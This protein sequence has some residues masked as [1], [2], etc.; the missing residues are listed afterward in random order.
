MIRHI[1]FFSARRQ[2]DIGAIRD[3][4]WRLADIPHSRFFEVA[5]NRRSDGL[6]REIDVVVHAGFASDAE[7]AAYRAHPIYQEVIDLVR[8]LR[9]LRFAADFEAPQRRPGEAGAGHER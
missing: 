8:P 7:L 9:A 6:S 3:G 5:E 2:E 1:V 4:L